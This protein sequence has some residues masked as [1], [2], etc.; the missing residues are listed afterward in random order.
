MGDHRSVAVSVA[1]GR[2]HV[3]FLE[4]PSK[5]HPTGPRADYSWRTLV[6]SV[7]TTVAG[8]SFGGFAAGRGTPSMGIWG[9]SLWP[10]V[11]V[12]IPL[13]ALCLGFSILPLAKLRCLLRSRARRGPTTCPVCGY[14]LRASPGRCPECGTSAD[15]LA[16]AE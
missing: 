13:Y 2:F 1:S 14:D 15:G 9:T 4:D 11:A 10:R 6:P 8:D 12:I 5:V 16:A 7:A 3:L